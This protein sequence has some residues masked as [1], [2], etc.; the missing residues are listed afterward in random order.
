MGRNEDEQH[1]NGDGN[2]EEETQTTVQEDDNAGQS[3]K[4]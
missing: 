4:S 3:G 1:I 2:G